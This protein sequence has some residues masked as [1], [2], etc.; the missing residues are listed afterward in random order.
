VIDRFEF[1]S[2]Y[3]AQLVID[4]YYKWYN[5]KRRYWSLNGQTPQTVWKN[6]NPIPFEKT[7]KLPLENCPVYKGPVQYK[8]R[9]LYCNSGWA[10]TLKE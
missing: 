8:I 5:E 1:E 6:Y 7:S 3:H 4:R 10:A 2:I 9:R